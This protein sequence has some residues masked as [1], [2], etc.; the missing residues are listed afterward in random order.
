MGKASFM[1]MTTQA[2]SEGENQKVFCKM[3]INQQWLCKAIIGTKTRTIDVATC[4]LNLLQDLHA[5]VTHTWKGRS[6]DGPAAAVAEADAANDDSMNEIVG[7]DDGGPADAKRRRGLVSQRRSRANPCKGKIFTFDLPSFCPG[8]FPNNK[9]TRCISLL[10]L[11]HQTIWLSIDDVDWAVKYLY[12]QYMV[13]MD[14]VLPADHPGQ[15]GVPAESAAPAA[16]ESAA[17]PPA[18]TEPADEAAA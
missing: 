7:G 17:A 3:S 12:A 2:V 1:A 14:E 11:D 16:A 15:H 8:A 4:R 9:E 18:E 5:L 6:S 10:I 13:K